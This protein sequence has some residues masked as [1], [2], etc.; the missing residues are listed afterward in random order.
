[1]AIF[2]LEALLPTPSPLI[3][4]LPWGHTREFQLPLNRQVH[5]DEF[6]EMHI[7]SCCIL[8]FFFHVSEH[9]NIFSRHFLLFDSLPPV[10]LFSTTDLEEALG[11]VGSP[12]RCHTALGRWSESRRISR[13]APLGLP[14][15]SP[16]VGAAWGGQKNPSPGNTVNCDCSNTWPWASLLGSFKEVGMKEP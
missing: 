16:L 6:S 14:V 5:E 9:K 7:S 15:V 10:P 13:H 3:V 12:C 2:P 8:R 11:R 1:M 4:W